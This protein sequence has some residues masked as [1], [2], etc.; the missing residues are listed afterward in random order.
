MIATFFDDKGGSIAY[1][2]GVNMSLQDAFN[3]TFNTH[4]A[5]TLVVLSDLP[6]EYKDGGEVV[7]LEADRTKAAVGKHSIDDILDKHKISI[8]KLGKLIDEGAEHE[9][10]HTDNYKLALAI[11]T[12]HI[13]EHLDYYQRLKQVKLAYGGLLKHSSNQESQ[14]T[15][16][17]EIYVP[18]TN[19]AGNTISDDELAVRVSSVSQELIK[20]FGGSTIESKYGGYQNH[21]E[22]IINERIVCVKAFASVND[23]NKHKRN[24]I[25]KMSKWAKQWGQESVAMEYNQRLYNV[26]SHYEDEI[27]TLDNILTMEE[28]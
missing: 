27:A 18:S 26:A 4:F 2:V 21:N 3:A 15:V 14:K 20:M 17:V 11:A 9:M 16:E 1:Q 13:Y 8:E 5:P 23:W 12:D 22:E 7:I 19:K 25:H 6:K 24:L 10:E 28:I